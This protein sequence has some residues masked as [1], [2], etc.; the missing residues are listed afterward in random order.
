MSTA[1]ALPPLTSRGF[2]IE[3]ET[4][5]WLE[6]RSPLLGDAAALRAAMDEHGHLLIRGLLDPADVLAARAAV[7]AML[8]RD[9]HLEPGTDPLRAVA[10]KGCGIK[11]KPEYANGNAAVERLLYTGA[12]VD[13]FADFFGG[14][15]AHYDFTWLRAVSPG[16][17]TPSH[18]DVVYMGRGDTR[19]L[20]TVWTPLGDVGF[21]LGGLMVLPGTHRHDRLRNTYGKY[22]VDTFCENKP[23]VDG[24]KRGGALADNPN[25]VRRSLGI[26]RWLTTE[27][28]AGDVLVFNMFT[29]HASL[30][31]P[32]DRIRLSTDS[33]YQ[34]AGTRM[35]E[36]W[37]GPNP[38]GHGAAG[39]RGRIC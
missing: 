18:C 8:E 6:D 16:H 27:F 39:K 31:N 2:A 25:Q 26:E 7:C 32:S 15:V 37:I 17:G 14:G 12:M 10:R 34:L 22:D 36:R 4:I 19:T 23:G 21:D 33:R 35:D 29:V 3:P 5:G 9:G 24:W 13:F 38:I 11:F 28:R 1:V 20:Y 30:D